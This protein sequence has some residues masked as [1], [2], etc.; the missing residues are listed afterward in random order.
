MCVLEFQQVHA[1]YGS[2]EILSGFSA[3]LE[4]GEFVGL[5]GANGAGKSTLIKCVSGLLSLRSGRILID[6]RDNSGLQPG[7]RAKKVA[8]VPQAFEVEY[9]F[10]VE[11]I[12]FMGRNPYIR[13]KGHNKAK[14]QELVNRALRM[15]KTEEF[16]GR[17]FSQLSGGEKQRVIIARAIAQ[18][19]EVILLDEP[20]SALDLSHQ[21][22]VMELI[23]RLN[24]E[25]G[26]TV[27]AVLHDVNLAA[28]Y[29]KRLIMLND[30]MVI[31]DGA[32]EQVIV[33]KNLN[34]IYHM[35]MMVRDNPLFGCPEIVPIRVLET[36]GVRTPLRIHV[37][38]G[39]TSAGKVLEQ[40]DEMGHDVSAGVLN[41][42]SGDWSVCRSLG[43]SMVEERPFTLITP[44]KQKENLA[45][46]ADADF[47]LIADLP[48]GAANI[49]N[50][51]G[52]ET[53]SAQVVFHTHCEDFT[54][55]MLE[56]RLRAIRSAGHL[57]EIEDH[58]QFVEMVR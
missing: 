1:G 27:V 18:E 15:T 51:L 46:M 10:T 20:T 50:L 8:V 45:M 2:R 37:I 52:L 38:C 42:G 30:G 35:K 21:I 40:L 5:I 26:L 28:R 49:N 41:E 44:E 16:A 32:P 14:D 54:G 6:G 39:G 24:E 43:L 4:P 29:C 22:E 19:P 12:V 47:I 57:V 9:D 13:E 48:F 53:Q 7:E 11:D 34:Q 33:K 58:S 23:R 17:L 56:E 31:A 3:R 25:E 36:E 55:G